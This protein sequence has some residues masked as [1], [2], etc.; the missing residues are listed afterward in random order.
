MILGSNQSP[1]DIETMVMVLNDAG[2]RFVEQYKPIEEVRAVMLR[3]FDEKANIELDWHFPI[4]DADSI[5]NKFLNAEKTYD[6][7]KEELSLSDDF[8]KTKII[9]NAYKNANKQ[10]SRRQLLKKIKATRT[11]IEEAKTIAEIQTLYDEFDPSFEVDHDDICPDCMVFRL[12]LV[13]EIPNNFFEGDGTGFIGNAAAAV[14]QMWYRLGRD[15]AVTEFDRIIRIFEMENKESVSVS[16]NTLGD[17]LK[18]CRQDFPVRLG[19]EV[20]DRTALDVIG[21][22]VHTFWMPVDRSGTL[23]TP[24][25]KMS[26]EPIPDAT[27]FNSTLEDVM[28]A[29]AQRIWDLDRDFR[30]YWSGGIDSTAVIVAFLRT[31]QSGDLERMTIVY[32]SDDPKKSSVGEYPKFF[33]DHIDGKLNKFACHSGPRNKF[34]GSPLRMLASFVGNDI[35][36]HAQSDVLCVT[37]ELGDQLFGSAAFSTNVDLINMDTAEYLKQDEFQPYLEDINRFNAACPL[38]TTKLVDALWWWNFAVKWQEVRYR[39]AVALEQCDRLQ[40][41][42]AFYSGEDFQKWSIANPDK[43]IKNTPES[44]KYSLK[45]FIYDYTGDAVYRDTKLKVGSLRVRVGAMAGIDDR[46]NII[47]FGDTSTSETLMR[48]RYGNTLSRFVK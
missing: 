38:D 17:G 48:E 43:K 9:V 14:N 40:N 33:A 28:L 15:C 47:K 25:V 42:H 13:D 31:A 18:F 32:S 12:Q 6:E 22:T 7:L 30:V 37:G 10:D 45:D 35:A 24:G 46:N 36:K 11:S 23:P 41:V 2:D 16:E 3:R 21:H 19:A 29:E 4:E 44:Y 34:Y 20:Q 1:S 8:D 26:V 5:Y 27:N 39:A